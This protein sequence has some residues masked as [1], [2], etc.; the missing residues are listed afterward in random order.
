LR[1]AASFL[2]PRLWLEIVV[3]TAHI[4]AND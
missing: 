1:E 2:Q 3:S 4:G